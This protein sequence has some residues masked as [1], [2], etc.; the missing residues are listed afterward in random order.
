MAWAD[1]IADD[2]LVW[3]ADS[4]LTGTYVS[5]SDAGNTSVSL[6]HIDNAQLTRKEIE[7]SGGAYTSLDRVFN[8]PNTLLG[9]VAKPGD[10]LTI[11]SESI[12][13]GGDSITYT[14]L[15]A[16]RQ[17]W[18]TVTRCVCRDPIICYQ[19]AQRVDVYEATFAQDEAASR[20]PTFSVKYSAVPAR[21]QEIS[22]E[23]SDE[24]GKRTMRRRFN[25][26]VAQH[27][28]LSTDDEI[29]FDGE[30]YAVIGWR[31][32]DRLGE[33]MTLECNGK[34]D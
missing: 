27:L 33:L 28:E 10:Y 18:G 6:T 7:A 9:L 20:V 3:A 30:R 34:D 29:R 1:L 4:P 25:I 8:I 11:S 21:I 19:L 12:T 14:V 2:Y 23:P 17:V 16:Q 31:N 32:P 15:D 5:V 22:G 26:F 24:R 13:N